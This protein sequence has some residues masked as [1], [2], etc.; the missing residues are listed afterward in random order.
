MIKKK[1]KQELDFEEF[2]VEELFDE[3]EEDKVYAA[4]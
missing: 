3:L 2:F 1:P 4:S